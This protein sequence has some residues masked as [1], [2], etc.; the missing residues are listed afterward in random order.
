MDR[1]IIFV[2][3]D[4]HKATVAVALAPDGRSNEIRFLGSVPHR[5]G[6]MGDLGKRLQKCPASAPM[7]QIEGA[8]F[9]RVLV[10]S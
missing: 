1:D 5:P 6:A 4:V 8:A 2:G 7:R 3:L 10:S 9:R